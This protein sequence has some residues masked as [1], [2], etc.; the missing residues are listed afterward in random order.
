MSSLT[1]VVVFQNS[2]AISVEYDV[3]D[4]VVPSEKKLFQTSEPRT[5]RFCFATSSR[6]SQA[7]VEC[8]FNSLTSKPLIAARRAKPAVVQNVA[9]RASM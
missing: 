2:F 9:F 1:Q 8:S 4:V 6:S 7:N 3:D 5:L